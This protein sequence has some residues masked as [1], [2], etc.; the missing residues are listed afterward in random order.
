M[1]SSLAPGPREHAESCGSEE[2]SGCAQHPHTSLHSTGHE[3]LRACL[4]HPLD[5]P[6]GDP[7]QELGPKSKAEGSGMCPQGRESRGKSRGKGKGH[8]HQ[9]M[10]QASLTR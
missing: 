5:N 2:C 8:R 3:G 1:P 4:H 9:P 10:K 6:W 7:S